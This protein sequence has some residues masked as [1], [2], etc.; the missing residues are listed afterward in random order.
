MGCDMLNNMMLQTFLLDYALLSATAVG[1]IGT[2]SQIVEI[3]FSILIGKF[4]DK[5]KSKFGRR[6]P[7]ILAGSILTSGAIVCLFYIVPDDWSENA[8]IGYYVGIMIWFSITF[9]A[10][11]IP[12][13]TLGAELSADFNDRSDLT[14][15]ATA[16]SNG[17]QLL[18]IVFL[19]LL[20]TFKV[21]LFWE[22]VCGS[23]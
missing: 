20:F 16:M 3:V 5:T 23:C 7:W 17:G 8:R 4:S 21:M 11:T 1:G 13:E 2:L 10:T 19:F 12:Y 14:T 22:I 6:R 9:P 18:V 15:W